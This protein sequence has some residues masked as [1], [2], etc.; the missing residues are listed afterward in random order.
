MFPARCRKIQFYSPSLALI[1]GRSRCK[2]EK[3][4]KPHG[5][6]YWAA[7]N[8]PPFIF[9]INISQCSSLQVFSVDK[10]NNECAAITHA[11]NVITGNRL[12]F[13]VNCRK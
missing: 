2:K 6:R 12:G 11:F 4:G 3:V 1:A 13:G 7:Y 8:A 5:G 9:Q 10:L